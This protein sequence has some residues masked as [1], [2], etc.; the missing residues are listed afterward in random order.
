MFRERVGRGNCP[1]KST[2]NIWCDKESEEYYPE[3]S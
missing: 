1:E 2:R 3:I